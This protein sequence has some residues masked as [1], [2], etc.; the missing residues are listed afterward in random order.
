MRFTRRPR[1][2]SSSARPGAAVFAVGGR[3]YVVCPS[4]SSSRVTLTDDPGKVPLA[5]LVDGSEVT[6]LAWR[7]GAAGAARYRV[8]VTATGTD[9][10]LPVGNLRATAVPVAPAPDVPPRSEA[11]P[12]PHREPVGFGP[13]FGQRRD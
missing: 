8:R 12:R 13:R 1:G 2:A 11:S 6:I 5:S 7:P 3:A 4:G 10:W 9:G